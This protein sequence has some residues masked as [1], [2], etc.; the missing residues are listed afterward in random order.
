MTLTVEKNISIVPGN[1][2]IKG[3]VLNAQINGLVNSE[4]LKTFEF[5]VEEK[6]CN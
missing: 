3:F 2:K 4:L 1:K 5:K 6:Q